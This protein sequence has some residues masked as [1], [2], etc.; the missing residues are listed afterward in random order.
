MSNKL[1]LVGSSYYSENYVWLR[2]QL[3][4]INPDCITLE[5]SIGSSS[6][7]WDFKKDLD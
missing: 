6:V 5:Q 2:E 1:T 4:L 3:D 7:Y